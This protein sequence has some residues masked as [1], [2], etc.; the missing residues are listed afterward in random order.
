MAGDEGRLRF[1]A[2]LFRADGIGDHDG[3]GRQLSNGYQPR[4]MR[5]LEALACGIG[6][7]RL[8]PPLGALA[9][10][11]QPMGGEWMANDGAVPTFHCLPILMSARPILRPRLRRPDGGAPRGHDPARSASHDLTTRLRQCPAR[12]ADHARGQWPQ[13]RQLR[14]RKPPTQAAPRRL[15]TCPCAVAPWLCPSLR[16]RSCKSRRCCRSDWRMNRPST[17]GSCKRWP[18]CL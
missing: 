8:S 9:S 1:A 14:R 4:S 17:A 15:R 3:V 11:R 13:T 16:R 10:R 18:R 12:Q 7:W 2:W 5:P 6:D